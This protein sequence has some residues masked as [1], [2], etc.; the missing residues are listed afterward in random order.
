MLTNGSSM[1]WVRLSS[2]QWVSVRW[3]INKEFPDLIV[4]GG[5]NVAIPAN[6]TIRVYPLGR[7]F[8]AA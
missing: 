1:C 8:D 5:N 7:Y 6:S 4:Y 3:E 2:T